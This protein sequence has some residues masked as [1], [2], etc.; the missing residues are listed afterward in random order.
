MQWIESVNGVAIL[1]GIII[2]V[3]NVNAWRRE[4]TG[5]RRIDLAEDALALFYE[6]VDAINHIRSPLSWSS[7]QEDIE[8]APGESEESW[9]AKKQAS[10]V[11]Q[12]F[13]HY[14]ELFNKI[15]AMRYRFMAQIGKEEAKPFDDLRTVVNEIIHSART[16]AQLWE[17]RDF[18][19][20]KRTNVIMNRWRS[21]S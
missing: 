21:M 16:L 6:A 8:R 7:E 13:K 10:V 4:Y 5:K 3:Y 12:R 20:L 14:E 2:A 15:H 9:R 1:I 11:F 17:R 19:P 18:N